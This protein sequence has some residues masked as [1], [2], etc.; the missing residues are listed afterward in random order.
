MKLSRILN[1]SPITYLKPLPKSYAF[2]GPHAVAV[3]G[4]NTYSTMHT[5]CFM[6][7]TKCSCSS[8]YTWHNVQFV[9]LG[10]S[11][12]LI[13]SVLRNVIA[14]GAACSCSRNWFL[15]AH[16]EIRTFGESTPVLS[17]QAQ[18]FRPFG[19]STQCNPR[20]P[21]LSVQALWA[22]WTDHRSRPQVGV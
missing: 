15:G 11:G 5:K 7:Y 18:R 13:V 21:D 20:G 14:Q 4:Y 22:P 17:G 6:Q 19:R 8:V 9:I 1:S 16:S 2:A 10:L 3:Q 12:V